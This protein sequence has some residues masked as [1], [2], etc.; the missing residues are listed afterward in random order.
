MNK[1]KILLIV[2]ILSFFIYYLISLSSAIGDSF[3]KKEF[4]SEPNDYKDILKRDNSDLA[5]KYTLSV[6]SISSVSVYTYD[7]FK[8]KFVLIVFKKRINK[9]TSLQSS[10]LFLNERSNKSSRKVYTNFFSLSG[11]SYSFGSHLNINKINLYIKGFKDDYI[12][13]KTVDKVYL[14]FPLNKTFGLS[15]NNNNSIDLQCDLNDSNI[16]EFNELM[17]LKRNEFVY[18]IYLKPFSENNNESLILK[19]LIK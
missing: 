13:D 1:T 8:S 16:E 7:K 12:K 5:Y 9:I 19:D 14:S 18:F 15:Y 17:I 11:L 6:D 3:S 10:T 4:V 2:A